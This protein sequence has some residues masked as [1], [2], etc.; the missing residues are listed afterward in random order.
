MNRAKNVMD[1]YNEVLINSKE[2]TSDP[3][4]N[5][6][7]KTDLYTKDYVFYD[8]TYL[9]FLEDKTIERGSRS[10]VAWAEGEKQRQRNLWRD[11][12]VLKLNRR[13]GC[14]IL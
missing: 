6:E 13:V 14:K 12:N 4:Y 7:V 5:L 2:E 9:K 3:V 11:G 1:V 8:S 10:V